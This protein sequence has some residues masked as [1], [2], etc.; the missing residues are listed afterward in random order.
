MKTKLSPVIFLF[1]TAIPMALA[2]PLLDSASPLPEP[3]ALALFAV[4][5]I[6]LT[7]LGKRKK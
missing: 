2:T 4:G 3:S 1:F 7:V 6:A 5:G